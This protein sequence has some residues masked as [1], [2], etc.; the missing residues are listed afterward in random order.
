MSEIEKLKYEIKEKGEFTD[1]M[2]EKVVKNFLSKFLKGEEPDSTFFN[3]GFDNG[4]LK[5]VKISLSKENLR[6]I[7]F[8]KD[9]FSE[10]QIKDL[11]VEEIIEQG[12]F[13]NRMKDI[14]KIQPQNTVSIGI[15]DSYFKVDGLG[16]FEGRDVEKIIIYRDKEKGI[17]IN[18]SIKF[19]KE[20][21]HGKTTACLAAGNRCGVIPESQLYL[22]QLN[23]VTR[24][25][26]YDYILKYI[27]ENNIKLDSL[28][29]PSFN[30][31]EE[32]IQKSL[33]ELDG[34]KNCEY[35]NTVDF[36]KNCAW[37]RYSDDG[38]EI[39]LDEI[40]EEIINTIKS[41][42]VKGN[43]MEKKIE[44]MGNVDDKVLI[45]CTGMTGIQEDSKDKYKYYGSVCGASFPT[46]VL[47]SIFATVRQINPNI[48]KEH[49]FEVMKETALI[50]S[51]GQKYLN[52]EG[53]LERIQEET[54]NTNREEQKGKDGLTDCI[55]DN[56][57]RFSDMQNATETT[58]NNVLEDANIEYTNDEKNYNRG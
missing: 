19:N 12:K 14:H 7:T 58:R 52:S 6:R 3:K 11:G 29:D 20:D 38:T 22:F 47:G 57:T 34:D 13:S 27:K 4:D 33:N 21:F 35:F 41:G 48:T 56:K 15:I 30:Q 28:I 46:T 23:G 24:K 26:A 54:K 51:R 37:G 32:K 18:S 17:T 16:E 5:G 2:F 1:E 45:P 55:E 53:L 40:A 39:E 43:G 44:V 25:E 42:K 31:K 10:E 36:W 50:N 8:V 9:A 49:F